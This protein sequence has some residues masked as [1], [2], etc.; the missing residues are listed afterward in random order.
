MRAEFDYA[1]RDLVLFGYL[2]PHLVGAERPLIRV[3]QAPHAPDLEKTLMPH[4]ESWLIES[5][6][7]KQEPAAGAEIVDRII[8][9]TSVRGPLGEGKN[10]RPDFI[11]V[12]REQELGGLHN[13]ILHA[14]SFEL[15][16]A[17]AKVADAV[18][19]THNHSA[20]VH[21]SHLVLALA[22]GAGPGDEDVVQ[23]AEQCRHH[24]VGFI[25]F[26]DKEDHESYFIHVQPKRKDQLSNQAALDYLQH[27][28]PA[29]KLK[30]VLPE[31]V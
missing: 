3:H 23:T 19:Q 10:S 11:A 5:W 16:S 12:V 30:R 18:R 26:T 8:A 7:P 13:T 22:P 17:G 1:I 2:K 14:H 27:R 9:D 31:R 4:V 6:L 25:S 20:N 15:K 29:E 28:I 24:G 21:F